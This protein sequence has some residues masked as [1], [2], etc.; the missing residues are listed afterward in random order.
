MTTYC[1][2]PDHSKLTCQIYDPNHETMITSYKKIKTNY[3]SQLSIN[4]ILKNEIEKKINKKKNK[5]V[6]QVNPS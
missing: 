1:I 2:D 3:E 4:P 6:T 5:K